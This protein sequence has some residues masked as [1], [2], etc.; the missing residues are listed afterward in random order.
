MKTFFKTTITLILF[1]ML[2]SLGCDNEYPSSLWDP[3][4]SSKP[5]PEVTNMEPEF[6]FSGIGEIT[7][8]GTNFSAV[9]EENTVF[10]NGKPAIT[11]SAT[12]TELVVQAPVLVADSARVKVYVVGAFL[13]G[14]YDDPYQ[15]K[16]A[17]LEYKAVDN[18]VEAFCLAVDPDENIYVIA[19][20]KVLQIAHPDS[21]AVQ[22]GTTSFSISSNMRWAPDGSIY[23]FRGNRLI[24]RVPPGGG[25]AGILTA[26][27]DLFDNI[28]TGDFDVNGNLFCGGKAQKIFYVGAA[29]DTATAFRFT[30]YNIGALRVYAG[31]L[32][33]AAKYAGDGTPAITE[34][35][36]RHQITSATG[37][38]GPQELVYDWGAFAGETGPKIMS[39]EFDETGLMYIG[40]DKDDA[41]MNLDLDGGTPT[42]LYPEILLPPSTNMRW[43]N[44][45]FIYIN[46]RETDLDKID[47]R[48][49]VRL[50]M[51]FKG[52]P[53]YGRP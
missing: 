31:Y 17:A 44:S 47:Q 3:N 53:S 20:K 10:F 36:W 41:I 48:R 25:R 5:T 42:P 7:L 12:T 8:T 13:Y 9:A 39:L 35:I 46:R 15:L 51:P 29:G 24:Y 23:I 22:Y 2:F 28:S 6:S 1:N 21:P 11:L 45:T 16:E 37:D 34:G 30:D 19:N 52:A 43:G 18:Q 26:F 4:Y 49:I 27:P 50:E 32:F 14:E 38:L 33:V 40:L